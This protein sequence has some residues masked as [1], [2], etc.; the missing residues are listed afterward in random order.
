[1]GKFAYVMLGV[2]GSGKTTAVEEIRQAASTAGASF[3]VMSF[4]EVRLRI[5]M[6]ATGKQDYAGA[7]SY[8]LDN[9][10]EFNAAVAAT[11][12][13]V[14]Q[15]DV[16]MVDNTNQTP[17]S[18]ARWIA[19]LRAKHFHITGVHLICSLET[20][21]E[22]QKTRGDKCVPANSVR[23]QFFNISGFQIGEV[24]DIVTRITE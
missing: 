14:L 9:R 17:K 3:G 7:F 6:E 20:L 12:K 22:R 10:E 11:W 24:D 16:V 21:L 18:R 19:D 8:S 5:Y 13:E 23:Q 4:D 1:M 15:C 2:S